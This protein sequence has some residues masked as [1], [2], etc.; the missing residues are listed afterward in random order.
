[1]ASTKCVSQRRRRI[2][3]LR[4]EAYSI[5]GRYFTRSEARRGR[6][7]R[8]SESGSL[9]SF[10]AVPLRAANSRPSYCARP[11]LQRIYALSGHRQQSGCHIE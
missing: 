10:R 6:P 4:R 11:T 8:D 9:L 5:C 3:A 2:S 7:L 1:V